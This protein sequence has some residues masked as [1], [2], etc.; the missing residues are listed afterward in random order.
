MSHVA[1]TKILPSLRHIARQS[2][3][4]AYAR[5][6]EWTPYIHLGQ[7]VLVSGTRTN[8]NGFIAIYWTRKRND[9]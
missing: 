1:G 2:R 9:A 7:W 4:Y 6:T 3:A 5:G 8:M